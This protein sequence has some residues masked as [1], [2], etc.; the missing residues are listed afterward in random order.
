MHARAH[1]NF[2]DDHYNYAIYQP[3]H[4]VRQNYGMAC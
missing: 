3:L 2:V 4:K 1:D